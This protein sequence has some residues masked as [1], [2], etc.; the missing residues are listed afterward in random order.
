MV[1]LF[2]FFQH[3]S[4]NTL[5]KIVAAQVIVSG[6][7][8][9]FN[10]IAVDIQDTDIKSAASQIINHDLAGL[11]LVKTV[12]KGCGSRLVDDAQY[13]QPGNEACVLCRLALGI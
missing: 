6:S 3:P 12:G 2:E 7:C 1:L 9:D 4:D 10:R 5:V 11:P 13:V 8:K